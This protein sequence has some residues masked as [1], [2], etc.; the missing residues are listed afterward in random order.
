VQ[1]NI[2]QAEAGGTTVAARPSAPADNG[3]AVAGASVEG[4]V[5]LA[6]AVKAGVTPGSVLFPLASYSPE[7]VAL[8]WARE[9]GAEAR[10]IDL[11]TSQSLA[12]ERAPEEAVE[13]ASEDAAPPEPQPTVHERLARGL[14]RAAA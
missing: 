4:S 11:T 9:H 2:A 7:Y 13:A 5:T 3:A 10:F 6:D 1:A 8:R 12:A 14:D